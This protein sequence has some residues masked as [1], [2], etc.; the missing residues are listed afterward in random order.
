MPVSQRRHIQRT[1][2]GPRISPAS[3]LDMSRRSVSRS[4][5]DRPSRA[6]RSTPVRATATR[7][8]AV[9]P[10]SVSDTEVERPSSPGPRCTYPSSAN[11]STSRT[12]PD[13]VSPSTWRSRST[14]GRSRKGS[15]AEGVAAADSG[16]PPASA[17]TSAIRSAITRERAP[18]R[19]A[20]WSSPPP[21]ASAELVVKAVRA[22]GLPGGRHRGA[23]A[24]QPGQ[25]ATARARDDPPGGTRLAAVVAAVGDHDAGAGPPGDLPGEPLQAGVLGRAVLPVVHERVR[26]QVTCEVAAE[27][28][29]HPGFG[30]LLL[31][32]GQVLEGVLLPGRDRERAF[33]VG[34]HGSSSA[35]WASRRGRRRSPRA[36]TDV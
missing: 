7:S 21:G 24:L 9:R 8:A 12:V 5:G 30:E 20:A 3:I 6:P 10:A 2:P 4:A 26:D 22:A 36:V 23:G 31:L 33:S 15:S 32:A 13:D 35:G 27:L 18:S 34:R 16:R 28:E 1:A 25:V 11:R 29:P 17:I 14:V 19:F